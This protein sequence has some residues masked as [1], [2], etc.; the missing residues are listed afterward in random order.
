MTIAKRLAPGILL[1][2]LAMR[3]LAYG[4]GGD[5][6]TI[7]GYVYDQGG[8]PMR[9]VKLTAISPT[10]I[11]G[12]KVTYSNE[13]GAFHIRSLI[14]GTFEVRATAPK[15]RQLVQKDVK[16]GITAAVE[17]NLVMEVETAVEQVTVVQKAPLVSTTKPNL[18]E[19]F[20]ADFVE[21][22]PHH[23][24]DNIHRDMLASVPGSVANRMRGGAANQTIVTQDGFDMGPPGK[25]IS[26]ALKSTAAFE[27]QTGGYGADNP[28][29]A[30]GLINLVT[31][32]GSNRFEFELN[33]TADDDRLRFFRDKRD[34]KAATFYYV[35]NPTV[36]GPIIKDKLWFF[37]NTE[38]HITQ[39][40]RQPDAEGIFPEPAPNQRFIQKG[41]FKLTWQVTKRNKVS[42]IINYEL[43]PKEINRIAGLGVAPEAQEIRSTQRIFV[44]TVWESLLTD[45][46][47]LRSQLG[48]TYIPEHIYPSLCDSQPVACDHIPSTIQTFPRQQKLDNNNNHT[49][50]DVYG[51]QLVN[52]LDWFVEQKAL[53]EHNL[54]IKDRFY[55]EQE[56]RKISHPGDMLYELN[57]PDPLWQTIYYSN[58]PR[59]EEA[60]YG[61][62]IG[63]D[64]LTKNVVTLSDN[65]RP[66]RHLTVTPSLSQVYA[67]SNDSG[68]N[69]VINATTW[70]PGL[71]AVWDATHD[72]RTAVR[73]SASTYVDVDVGAVARHMIGGQAQKRC[74]WSTTNNAY[75]SS[76][77]FSGGLSKNTIGSPCGP[78]GVDD[79]GVS[80]K[81]S[82]EVPR[83]YEYTLGAEREVTAGIALS[84]DF[85][86]KVY[87]NQYEVNETNRIWNRSGTGLD[88]LAGYK[89]GRPETI[90]DVGTPDGARRRYDGV[91]FGVAKREGRLKAQISYTWSELVGTVFNGNSNPYG[92]IPARD[93]YLNG[94]LP[95]DHRHEV[96]AIMSFQATRWL[97][98]GTRTTYTSGQ[99]YDRVFRNDETTNYDQY[100]AS[101]GVNPGAVVNDASDDR[102]LR[103]PDVFEL[104]LQARVNLLPLI[105]KRFDIYV[106]VLNALALRPANAVGTNDGQDFGVERG[107]LDPFRLRLGLDFKF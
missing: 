73:G 67:V 55:T 37:F 77:V 34:P 42:G 41:S 97:S 75:D 66:T 95:D 103:L 106:D 85:I 50:T 46:L 91:T 5:S 44:G 26:P 21:A 93:V 54:Q 36:A 63:T 94:Y 14:P 56:T 9:G 27:V 57:G 90:N 59:Y 65:W 24:R 83:T 23:T 31:R 2:F 78:S 29:A 87:T 25:T 3:G 7:S 61:W 28:T 10:Q 52:Q 69:Q 19:E 8:N 70:A 88:T 62:F 48:A 40:G 38:T 12:A 16:V 17:L 30:G 92:D 102:P 45:N 71:A 32:S 104:N 80:C 100:R 68:G 96:K 35:I 105:G 84:L 18:R 72:G 6:G 76:C 82:L 51:L 86:H 81:T 4:Q 74:K 64:T 13:E 11:G 58:D 101:R 107:W 47:V 99:P 49:R 39:D 15:V 1:V 20:D 33:A 22:L 53:G 89:N 79:Q 43:I 60:R 98:L